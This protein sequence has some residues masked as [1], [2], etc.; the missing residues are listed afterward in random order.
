MNNCALT[1]AF[2]NILMKLFGLK[3]Q[4]KYAGNFLPDL[5]IEH[6]PEQEFS[7]LVISP[8]GYIMIKPFYGITKQSCPIELYSY[9]FDKHTCEVPFVFGKF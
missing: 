8:A 7:G 6:R 3:F 4:K 2:I 9:P 5:V 1:K